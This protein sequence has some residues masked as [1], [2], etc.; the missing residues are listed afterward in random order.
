MICAWIDTSAIG[1]ALVQ[2]DHVVTSSDGLV[3]ADSL[4]LPVHSVLWEWLLRDT[5]SSFC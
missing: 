5:S 2:C 3:I 4:R 1:F